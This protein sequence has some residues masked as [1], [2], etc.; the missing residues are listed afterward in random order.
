MSP[1][2]WVGNRGHVLVV[3][4]EHFE[5]LY[6]IPQGALA[7]VYRI[8]QRAA[9]AMKAAYGCGGTSTR[10]HNEPAGGQDVWHFHVHV[11]PRFLNDRLYERNAETRWTTPEKR[12]PYA[13]LL[14][15]HLRAS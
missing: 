8:V 4:T 5:N 6:E 2:W 9:V 15:Q 3:P 11:F 12:Q 7:A 10:Q 14:R 1:K 13:E